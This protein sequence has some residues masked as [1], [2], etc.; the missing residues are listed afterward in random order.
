MTMKPTLL[1]PL[2]LLLPLSGRTQPARDSLGIL[3][4]AEL[5]T[6]LI[7]ELG[8]PA[9]DHAPAAMLYRYPVSFSAVYLQGDLRRESRP[10][11]QPEG[12]GALAGSFRADS[13]LRLG[14]RSAVTAGASYERGRT[15]NI[16]WNSTADYRLLR[17]YVAADSVGGDL[18]T[19]TYAFHGTYMRRDGSISYGLGADYRAR[20]EY[21]QV[22]PRPRNI[23]NDLSV[24]AGAGFTTDRY[25]VALS[26]RGRIYKQTQEVTFYSPRGANAVELLMLGLGNCMKRFSGAENMNNFY[27]GSGYAVTL[28][29][30]PVQEGWIAAV[31]YD[32]FSLDRQ[33]SNKNNLSLG[34]LVTQTLSAT[35]A[36]RWQGRAHSGGYELNASYELRQGF[37]NVI[38]GGTQDAYLVLGDFAMYR[39]RTFDVA[40]KGIVE[41]RRPK[42]SYA[43]IPQI[44]YF[45]T[46]ADYRHPYR[47]IAFSTAGAGCDLQLTFHG[48]NGR[49]RA[50]L[51]GRYLSDLTCDTELSAGEITP[52]SLRQMLLHTADRFTANAVTLTTA[53]RAERLL[54][55]SV[56]LFVD[57][58]WRPSFYTGGVHAHAATIACGI[59]F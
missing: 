50:T 57:A 10:I 12:D 46:M 37:E 48:R 25:V 30:A 53:L 34:K 43:L 33:F 26:A 4:R 9:Y 22:D 35:L 42:T 3:R 20:H 29:V 17:P 28:S 1:L 59:C 38:S 47:K 44:A 31:G 11:L 58:S 41:W 8:A 21:R 55:R 32:R 45:R 54:K 18:S 56:A 6:A 19:E 36:K 15:D 14:E 40:A 51:G 52:A 49:I 13:Y 2:C 5:R 23:V 16:R 27:K 7:A 24:A 39:N